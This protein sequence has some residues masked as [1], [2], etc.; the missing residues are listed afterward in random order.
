M[1]QP[2][3]VPAGDQALK[4]LFENKIDRKINQRVKQL[5]DRISRKKITGIT[6]TI[7]AFRTLT[8]LYDTLQTDYHTL[9]SDIQ[10]LLADLDETSRLRKRIIEIPV[11]YDETLGPDLQAVAE[12]AGLSVEEVIQLHSEPD[13]LIYMLGFLP[14]FAYLGEMNPIISMPRL[15]SPRLNIPAGA[16][17]IAGDQTGMYPMASPGGWRI[18]GSTPVKL[19]D[20]DRESPILYEAG[21][22]IR[23]RPISLNEYEEMISQNT[24]AEDLYHVVEEDSFGDKDNE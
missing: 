16:V 8:V 14:G 7:P 19:F 3:I 4:V 10:P 20:A 15:A 1:S 11:C 2:E 21:D 9:L 13:Y 22:Y 24:N 12:H 6:E 18:I 23:F 17:G 5:S